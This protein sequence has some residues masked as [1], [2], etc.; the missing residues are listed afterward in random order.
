V[1][2]NRYYSFADQGRIAAMNREFDG[3]MAGP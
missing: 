3:V 2:A 1:G